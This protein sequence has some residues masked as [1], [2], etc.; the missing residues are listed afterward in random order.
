MREQILAIIQKYPKRFSQLIKTDQQLVSW[1]QE[2]SQVQSD[3]FSEMIYSAVYQQSSTC[4]QGQT[5]P[6]GSF[7]KGWNFC[8]NTCACS[9]QSRSQKVSIAKQS[10]DHQ[11][12][13]TINSKRSETMLEKYGVAFNSQRQDIHSIWKRPKISPQV[14]QLL[15]NPEWLDQ[16]YNQNK[17]NL[18][19]IADQLGVYYS[20]VGEYCR[21]HGFTIRQRSNY[22]QEEMAISKWLTEHHLDHQL[23]VW[24]CIAGRELD[25]YIPSHNL[26]IELNGLYWHSW[27]P[28]TNKLENKQRH[29]EKTL[30]CEAKNIQLLHITD[31]EWHSQND[32][33][34]NLLSSKLN[35]NQTIGARKCS[36]SEIKNNQANSLLNHWH[37]QKSTPAH[38]SFALIYQ[39]EPVM[40]I[41]IGQSRFNTVYKYELLRLASK[42]GINVT[43][44]LSKLMKYIRNQLGDSIIS[45]CD[46]SKSNGAGY[47]A[48]GFELISSTGPG[49]FWTNGTDQISRY[50]SQKKNLAKFLANYCEQQSES[51]NMFANRWRRYWDCGNWVFVYR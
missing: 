4:V 40:V 11:Q 49:Y 31:R 35:L 32:Q 50:Q 1:V 37:L 23:G 45:Y 33:I 12:H 24:D 28:D 21:H 47:L 2:N 46:R 41:T 43:G 19:D 42:P 3:N 8:K 20:T 48:S 38:R 30:A 34:V 7:K 44:G 18:V 29:L 15:S 13:R 26:A 39:N 25:I 27:H 51:A 14:H 17:R 16:E 6:F 9:Q 5:R 10:L 22:S 36:L